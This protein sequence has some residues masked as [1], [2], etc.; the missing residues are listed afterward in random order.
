MKR[1]VLF[2]AA[3]VMVSTV[4]AGFKYEGEWGK[5]GS[6]QGEFNEPVSLSV[7]PNGNVYVAE[8]VPDRIQ[9]F[10]PT[11]S[12]LKSWNSGLGFGRGHG[13]SVSPLTG[14]VYAGGCNDTRINYYTPSG[15]LLGSWI[16]GA[17][18]T[19]VGGEVAPNGNV[20]ATVE[21]MGGGVIYYTPTG[22]LLGGW[23]SLYPTRIGIAPNG[24][25]YVATPN[26]S[27]ITYYT[28]TGSEIGSWTVTN[29]AG[30]AVAPDRRVFVAFPSDHVIRY[31]TPSGSPL[32]S[33][34]AKGS[35]PGEF[36]EPGDV[37]LT[38]DGKR[39]YVAD[40][41]NHRIQYFFEDNQAV[42]PESLGK[43]KALFR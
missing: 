14:N 40:T 31:Y 38:A 15:S 28:S 35:G 18:G 20:Y 9:C 4:L 42:A 1:L 34:G 17:S 2:L 25:V 19:N 23:G 29:Q 37:A 41:G 6:G 16:T 27:L 43:V 26:S 7:A 32:G 10:T 21:Y 8:H 33:W 24:D 39:I 22:S 30:I 12:F 36:N 13:V 3:A 5:Y 11:G